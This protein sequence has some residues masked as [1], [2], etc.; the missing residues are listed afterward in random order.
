MRGNTVNNMKLKII[1]KIRET[2]TRF[3]QPTC[4]ECITLSRKLLTSKLD[5]KIGQTVVINS[6]Q[7][8]I[9][10]REDGTK[11]VPYGISYLEHSIPIS[12]FCV[13]ECCSRRFVICDFL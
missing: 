8:S 13:F 4:S 12:H 9:K 3:L 7:R 11:Y 5:T 1:A 2:R 6:G 10:K